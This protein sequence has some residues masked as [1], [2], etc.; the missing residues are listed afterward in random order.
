MT[1]VL[2]VDDE[3]GMRDTLVDIL[4]A[5]GHEARAVSS[6]ELAL[7]AV[8]ETEYDVVVMDIRMPGRDGVSVLQEMG[9]PPPQVIMMTAYAIEERLREALRADAFAIVHKPFSVNR[10][11]DLVVGAAQAA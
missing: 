11:L 1:R 7:V 10:L 2:I 5:A 4:C 8:R 9:A 3:A 6:G